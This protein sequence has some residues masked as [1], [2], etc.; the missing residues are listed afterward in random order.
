[1][2]KNDYEGFEKER[3]RIINKTPRYGNDDDVADEIMVSVFNAYFEV[4][5]GR[6]NTKGGFYAINLLPTT[7]HVYFGSKT[8][9]TPDG[10]ELFNLYPKVF[11]LYR[12]QTGMDQQLSSNLQLN[13]IT[14]V[15]VVHC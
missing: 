13:W 3:L 1:M 5:D 12:G 10:G 7:S 8:G 15:Q 4:V 9:A 11:P 2:L 6:P 14:L